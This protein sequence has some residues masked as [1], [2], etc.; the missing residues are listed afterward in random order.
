MRAVGDLND[1]GITDFAIA[2]PQV[3]ASRLPN[4]PYPVGGIVDVVAGGR[5]SVL[6]LPQR[7]PAG[8]GQI[9]EL[10]ASVVPGLGTDCLRIRFD[11][12]PTT[13]ISAVVIS[14][15]PSTVP[16]PFG[17]CDEYADLFNGIP[18]PTGPSGSSGSAGVAIPPAGA[19]PGLELG[20][21]LYAQAVFVDFSGLAFP[22]FLSLSEG[23]Q[24]VIR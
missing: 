8:N 18:I 1:D 9:I 24:F 14:A 15:F 10:S 4:D 6:T 19:I 16:L 3:Q 5:S 12:A 11:K 2:S 13:T 7:C 20:L 22:G 23:L 21:N 17:V